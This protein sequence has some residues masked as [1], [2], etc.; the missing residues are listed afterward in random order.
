MQR[1]PRFQTQLGGRFVADAMPMRFLI[2]R[3]F[4]SNNKDQIVGTAKLGRFSSS[5]YNSEGA[6]GIVRGADQ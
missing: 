6:G 1:P 5:L 4:N 3:A 2:S